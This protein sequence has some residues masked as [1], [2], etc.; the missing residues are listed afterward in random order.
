MSDRPGNRGAEQ[1]GAEGGSAS[2]GEQAVAQITTVMRAMA[3]GDREA[4]ARLLPLVYEDLRRLAR[5]RM[6]GLPRGN[7]LQ[8]TALV[9]EA[10]MRVV[11]GYAGAVGRD[12]GW[13][14]RG[15]F[16]G[17]AARAMRDILV[18]QARRKSGPKAGGAHAR[19]PLD[20]LPPGSAGDGEIE[21]PEPDMLALETALAKLEKEDARK[22]EVV[23][24]K[25]FAGL[26]HGQIA[27]ILGVSV[28]TVER[29]WRFARSWLQ[30]EMGR[31][32]S[33]AGE[34]A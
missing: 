27:E 5:Q 29:D 24:L 25:Y 21:A 28:P 13:E 4:G 10:Y 18:E 20:E 17:A 2:G 3:D 12:P 26:E 34:P 9:H 6:S 33:A 19:K 30:S 31:G 22:G 23:M 14:S 7:T 15:H 16:F 1:E 32:D 8:P 11:G